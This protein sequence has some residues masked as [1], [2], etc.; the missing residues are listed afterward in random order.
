MSKVA[1][2]GLRY[3]TS[4]KRLR[5]LN[6]TQCAVGTEGVLDLLKA[7]LPPKGALHELNVV[8]CRSL[9]REERHAAGLGLQGLRKHFNL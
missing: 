8:S 9:T 2:D 5:S 6:V 7:L 3:L 1:D 4:C